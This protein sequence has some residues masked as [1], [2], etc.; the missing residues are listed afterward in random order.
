[1]HENADPIPQQPMD[2]SQDRDIFGPDGTVEPFAV[3]HR[4]SEPQTSIQTPNVSSQYH[5]SAPRQ[6][7]QWPVVVK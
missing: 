1:M 5:W 3:E 7:I 4:G 6:Q 2:M